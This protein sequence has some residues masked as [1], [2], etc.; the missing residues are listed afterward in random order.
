MSLRQIAWSQSG[1]KAVAGGNSQTIVLVAFN[2]SEDSISIIYSYKSNLNNYEFRAITNLR[3]DIFLTAYYNQYSFVMF[4]IENNQFE[5]I[6]QFYINMTDIHDIQIFQNKI[7]TVN[8]EQFISIF[9]Y[10]SNF[11]PQN[12]LDED[13]LYQ[14]SLDMN[15]SSYNLSSQVTNIYSIIITHD[16]N[17]LFFRSRGNN[18]YKTYRFSLSYSGNNPLHF[19]FRDEKHNFLF[20]ES[21]K[22]IYFVNKIE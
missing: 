8:V 12:I 6:R 15:S 11:D 7:F 10:N 1:L 20:R 21:R 5:E 13:I 9:S 17:H 16:Q 14:K 18:L 19:V 3:D 2:T 4:T 22:I